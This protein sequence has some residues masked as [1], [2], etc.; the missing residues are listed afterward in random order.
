M[1]L[2]Q[3]DID[4]KWIRL[5][6]KNRQ[7]SLELSLVHIPTGKMVK[8]TIQEGKSREDTQD[9]KI[10]LYDKLFDKLEILVFG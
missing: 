8:E 7:R 4:W 10:E 3:E 9:R 6:E 5:P 1:K 2:K